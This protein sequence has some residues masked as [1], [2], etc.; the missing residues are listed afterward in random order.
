MSEAEPR[1]VVL[2]RLYDA[3]APDRTIDLDG[4]WPAKLRNDLGD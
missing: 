1:P 2:A 4:D 3:R